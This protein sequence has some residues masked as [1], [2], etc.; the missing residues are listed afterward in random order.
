[1]RGESGKK[2]RKTGSGR[3]EMAGDFFI[4]VDPYLWKLLKNDND[5]F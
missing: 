1:M 5:D 4:I 2:Y 3:I